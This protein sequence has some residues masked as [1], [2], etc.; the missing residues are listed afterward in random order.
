MPER[1]MIHVM[2][3]GARAPMLAGAIQAE[4]EDIR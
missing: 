3:R 4:K 1:H 2:E